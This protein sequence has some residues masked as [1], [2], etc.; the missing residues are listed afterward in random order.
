MHGPSTLAT[1]C[2]EFLRSRQRCSCASPQAFNPRMLKF[3]VAD[4]ST[5]TYPGPAIAATS[6]IPLFTQTTVGTSCID[7]DNM[8]YVRCEGKMVTFAAFLALI[9]AFELHHAITNRPAF[10]AV[11][12]AVDATH[13]RKNRRANAVRNTSSTLPRLQKQSKNLDQHNYRYVDIDVLQ[14]IYS[15]KYTCIEETLDSKNY[16]I[17]SA[18]TGLLCPKRQC[19]VC[20]RV[21]VTCF[22]KI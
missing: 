22:A 4:T 20:N 11:G 16:F 9:F 2:H 10:V 3:C 7:N 5:L 18:G 17:H 13:G 1:C 19:T 6:D 8:S 12:N 14:R 21:Q 15:N